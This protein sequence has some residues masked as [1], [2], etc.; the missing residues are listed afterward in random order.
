MIHWFVGSV[1]SWPIAAAIGRAF[2]VETGGVPVV[3]VQRWVHDFPKIDPGH[4]ARKTFRYYSRWSCLALG[5]CFA[6]MTTDNFASQSNTWYN[7]PD[8]KPFPAMV[9]QT[10]DVTYQSMKEGQYVPARKWD[11]K[12]S[13]VY[14]YFFDRD[15]D[16]TLKDNPYAVH[17]EDRWDSRKGHFSTYSNTFGQHHQ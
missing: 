11:V 15:A 17:P 2:K 16:F 7:R 12:R 9:E 10:K 3:P 13:A 6:R 14:R 5:Y 1:L 4:F 8:L